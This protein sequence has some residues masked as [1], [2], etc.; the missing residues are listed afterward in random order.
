MSDGELTGL[1][2]EAMKERA[3]LFSVERFRTELFG[4]VGRVLK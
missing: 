1:L 3:L 2:R 4:L